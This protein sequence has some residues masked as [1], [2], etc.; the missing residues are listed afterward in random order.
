MGA[1]IYLLTLNPLRGQG[2]APT[3]NPRGNSLW[4]ELS[5]QGSDLL[6]PQKIERR[7]QQA[8]F[9]DDWVVNY[10]LHK[11]YYLCHMFFVFPFLYKYK[12]HS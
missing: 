5:K 6:S 12:N 7:G 1:V 9:V 11:G 8:Y 2:S 10:A 4:W 3:L